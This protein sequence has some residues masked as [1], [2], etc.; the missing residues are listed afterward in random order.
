MTE[1]LWSVL[2]LKLDDFPLSSAELEWITGYA[3][4]ALSSGGAELGGAL[5]GSIDAALHWCRINDFV[6]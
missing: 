6:R 2:E 5:P 3:L 1:P 4:L